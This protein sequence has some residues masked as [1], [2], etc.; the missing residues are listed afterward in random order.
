MT[1]DRMLERDL[2]DLLTD[3]YMGP[4]PEYRDEILWQTARTRQRPEWTFP[5]R[6]FPL[7][8]FDR[9]SALTSALPWRIVGVALLVALLLSAVVYVAMQ[10]K[11]PPPFGLAMNGLIVFSR[12]GDI[13]TGDPTSGVIRAVVTGPEVDLEPRWSLDGTRFVFERRSSDDVRFG[14]LFVARADGRNLTLATPGGPFL[15]FDGFFFA[16]DGKEVVFSPSFMT[17]E[18]H[19]SQALFV[20]RA[21]GGGVRKLDVGLEVDEPAWRPPDGRQIIFVG[22]DDDD[23]NGQKG[24]YLVNADG[25][26]LQVVVPPSLQFDLA[27]PKWSPDGSQIAYTAWDMTID[28]MSARQHLVS[29]DGTN[30][31]LTTLRPGVVWEAAAGWSNDGNRLLVIRSYTNLYENVFGAVFPADGSGP[32]VQSDR[33]LMHEHFFMVM[34]WSPDDS[35]ILVRPMKLPEENLQQVYFNPLS[36]KTSSVEWPATSV[37]AWQRLAR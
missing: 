12:D 24:L 27:G 32:D 16:P 18:G 28:A 1:S 36:G 29:A 11:L 3:L 19:L 8:G 23:L 15:G 31:R 5:E 26:N 22:K 20:A 30:D 6:W 21:D 35:M 9:R 7:L 14:N 13:Y 33:P 10:P 17:A 37:P 2:P 34:E 25:T 4:A